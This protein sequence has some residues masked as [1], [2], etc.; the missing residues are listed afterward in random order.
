MYLIDWIQQKTVWGTARNGDRLSIIEH[1]WLEDSTFYDSSWN[2]GVR[3]GWKSWWM[4]IYT[5]VLVK[6]QFAQKLVVANFLF[7]NG[8]I[9]FD[10]TC[11]K[12][13]AS[14]FHDWKRNSEIVYSRMGRLQ[15]M[16]RKLLRVLPS[17]FLYGEVKKS[18]YLSLLSDLN[19]FN[20]NFS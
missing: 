7:Q 1:P 13:P 5:T 10:R 2:A 14:Y 12:D 16:K 15:E 20:C 19:N 8:R 11:A 3:I 4:R 18:S 9:R 6:W 17:I